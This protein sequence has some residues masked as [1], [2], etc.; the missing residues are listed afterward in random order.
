M[1]GGEASEA[2]PVGGEDE[3]VGDLFT[4]KVLASWWGVLRLASKLAL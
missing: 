1:K 3:L 4:S 2:A